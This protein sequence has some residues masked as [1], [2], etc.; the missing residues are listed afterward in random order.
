[1]QWK[2]LTEGY[3]AD[4]TGRLCYS[5]SAEFLVKTALRSWDFP[6]LSF[7]PLWGESESC[8]LLRTKPVSLPALWVFV[9]MCWFC[10]WTP[11]PPNFSWLFFTVWSMWS[12]RNFQD[13]LIHLSH[14]TGNQAEDKWGTEQGVSEYPF[15]Y[16]WHLLL[17]PEPTALPSPPLGKDGGTAV[18][19]EAMQPVSKAFFIPVCVG[20]SKYLWKVINGIVSPLWHFLMQKILDSNQFNLDS[21]N[22]YFFFFLTWLILMI[23]LKCPEALKHIWD[24]EIALQSFCH[25]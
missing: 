14:F 18:I 22:C 4:S 1:M 16:P 13:H 8:V 20:D 9:L 10:K 5:Q 17:H 12:W 11:G 23:F 6:P 19:F 25:L 24:H 21:R 3:L 15:L 7:P 2:E